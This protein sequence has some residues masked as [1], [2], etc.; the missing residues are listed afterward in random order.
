[1]PEPFKQLQS[2][3]KKDLGQAIDHRTA[4]EQAPL[5]GLTSA[6]L[7]ANV[8]GAGDATAGGGGGEGSDDY[9]RPHHIDQTPA[10]AG[11]TYGT[12]AGLVNGSNK[13]FTTA[14]SSYISGQLEVER[15]GVGQSQGSDQS[16]VETD[17]SAGTFDFVTAPLSGDHI[18]VRY[19]T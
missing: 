1:M 8:T 9:S 14:A 6:N 4:Q 19:N 10:G 7:G 2:K 5:E 17:P 3:R 18:K 16:W 12:L 15:N 11:M 13:T